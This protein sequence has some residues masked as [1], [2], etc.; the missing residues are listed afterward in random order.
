MGGFNMKKFIQFIG[1][2]LILIGAFMGGN[3]TSLLVSVIGL[4][5]FAL[6]GIIINKTLKNDK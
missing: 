1:M 6:G 3:E 2:L 5:P 4:V